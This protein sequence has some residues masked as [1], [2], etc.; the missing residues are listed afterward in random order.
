[1]GLTHVGPGGHSLHQKLGTG[2]M[3]CAQGSG[4]GA[5]HN[6]ACCG[7]AAA[8]HTPQ[9]W[10]MVGVYKGATPTARSGAPRPPCCPPD[11]SRGASQG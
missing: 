3:A 10:S 7:L 8:T 5:H 6:A 1:M 9:V 11:S 2:D 4:G